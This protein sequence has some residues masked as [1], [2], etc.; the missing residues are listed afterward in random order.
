MTKKQTRARV[1]KV[2]TEYINDPEKQ[3]K[4]YKKL[5]KQAQESAD[6]YVSQLLC[7]CIC[8]SCDVRPTIRVC[9]T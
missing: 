1:I 7:S 3:I 4:E 2:Y 5:L 8:Y 9:V 6:L